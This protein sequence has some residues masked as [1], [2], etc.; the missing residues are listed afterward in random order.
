[1]RTLS[2]SII[3]N[4]KESQN[5]TTDQKKDF[6]L[7]Y[8]R[9]NY[10]SNHDNDYKNYKEVIDD[11]ICIVGDDECKDDCYNVNYWYNY[12]K[13]YINSELDKKGE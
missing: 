9:N 5:L 11:L 13:D 12:L 8:G 6:I 1:M 10:I 3:F 7:N 4:L 2:E